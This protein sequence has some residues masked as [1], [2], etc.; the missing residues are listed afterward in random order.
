MTWKETEKKYEEV[1]IV[2]IEM[3]KKLS[4]AG[5]DN[6]NS[7]FNFYDSWLDK[8]E[9]MLSSNPAFNQKKVQVDPIDM[10]GEWAKSWISMIPVYKK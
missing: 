6:V 2:G 3:L 4:E 5:R 7:M 9:S 10:W 1:S 8:M